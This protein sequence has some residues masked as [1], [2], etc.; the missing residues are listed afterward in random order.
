MIRWWAF[1]RRVQY[2]TGFF[3]LLSLIAVSV[4]FV[5][6]NTPPTCFDESQNG[7]E[8]GVDC[9]GACDRICLMDVLLPEVIWSEAFKIVDG[10][11]NVVAY[12]E[13]RNRDIGSPTLSYTFK[14]YDDAGLI[15]ER[16]GST[17]LPPDGAYPIFEG[18]IMT[19]SRVPTKTTLAFGTEA[20]WRKGE[21][22]RE[23]FELVR[24]ELTNADSKPRLAAELRNTSLA[25]AQD[26]EIIATI[27]D[28]AKRPLTASR[29]FLEYFPGRSA[30]EVI[31]TWPEPIAKTL[32][33]CETPTDVVLA[34]DL[35]G[36][37]NNDGANPPEPVTSVLKAAESFVSRLGNRDQ[38]GVVTYATN[39]SVVEMLTGDTDRVARLVAKLSIDPKEETGSTNTGEALK[40]MAEEL[41]SERHSQDARRVAILLT[42]GLA[43]AP[44]ENPDAY[45]QTHASALKASG[46][47]LFT[48]G[49][50][51]SVNETFLRGLA[52][53]PTQY[54][55]A[56]TIRE[57]QTIYTSITKDICEEGPAVIEIIAKPKTSFK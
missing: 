44:D 29:T 46:A 40:R 14:L 21:V 43:T 34:I 36:S 33:S 55:K 16:T 17:V 8:R 4:Y 51:A 12:V 35:S 18:R 10:Q 28:S 19:G 38:I 11:Y 9:G 1:W 26:V 56:P 32:R 30:Q 57:L 22:G 52:S 54:Y 49:L 7:D 31:F 39:A 48:I 20:L 24:R 15:V 23:Q 42:D 2:A 53:S 50:G 45:A 41:S 6:F 27:F 13:N 3:L 5:H 37:M 25:E 47:Q